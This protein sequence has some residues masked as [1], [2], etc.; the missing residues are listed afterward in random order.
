[1][2]NSN[3][4][5][6]EQ[7]LRGSSKEQQVQG[8]LMAFQGVLKEMSGT[9]DDS[10]TLHDLGVH[11][12]LTKS[13]EESIDNPLKNFNSVNDS[14]RST[15][16][17]W[18][19]NAI[20]FLSKAKRK[21]IKSVALKHEGSASHV[22]FVLKSDTE[23]IRDEFYEFSRTYEKNSISQDF[24]VVF[25]FIDFDLLEVLDDIKYINLDEQQAPQPVSSK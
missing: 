11:N 18:K 23:E 6:Q 21:Y 2:S 1:M 4:S 25:H 7:D 10:I 22:F 8:I 13:I 15:I 16:A 3:L 24:P 19:E 9:I 20:S 5:T 14:V 17:D 12:E